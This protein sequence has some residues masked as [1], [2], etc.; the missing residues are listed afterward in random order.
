M[1]TMNWMEI[2]KKFFFDLGNNFEWLKQKWNKKSRKKVQFY[3]VNNDDFPEITHTENISNAKNEQK[4]R[5]H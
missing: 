5:W 3:S 1:D 4:F 2:G